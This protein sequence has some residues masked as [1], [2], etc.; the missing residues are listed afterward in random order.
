MAHMIQYFLLKLLLIFS[1]LDTYVKKVL[2]TQ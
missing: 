1:M 2:N